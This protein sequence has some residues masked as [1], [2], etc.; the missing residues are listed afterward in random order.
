[1][2]LHGPCPVTIARAMSKVT[3]SYEGFQDGGQPQPQPV[4]QKLPLRV[5]TDEGTPPT[6]TLRFRRRCDHDRDAALGA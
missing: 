4:V 6:R 1:M 5:K 3:P 2:Q